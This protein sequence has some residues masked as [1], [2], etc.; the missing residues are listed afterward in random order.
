MPSVKGSQL[1]SLDRLLFRYHWKQLW[2]RKYE[3]PAM[4]TVSNPSF[5]IGQDEFPYQYFEAPGSG[6]SGLV[7]PALDFRGGEIRYLITSL[8]KEIVLTDIIGKINQAQGTKVRIGIR[9]TARGIL[10]G[11]I[12]I[13]GTVDPVNKTHDLWLELDETDLSSDIPSARGL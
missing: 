4:V 1:V 7:L 11:L 10:S 3:E 5:V 8:G 2:N 13:H 9:A 6:H 12:A